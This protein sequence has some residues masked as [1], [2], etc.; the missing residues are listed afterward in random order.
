MQGKNNIIDDILNA[1]NK[2][3]AD[4]ISDAEAEEAEA[5]RAVREELEKAR[6]EHDAETKT[7][8]DALYA[9]RVKLGELEAGKIMLKAKRD[10][11]DKVYDGVRKRVLSMKDAEYLEFLG[12]LIVRACEDGDEVVVS[13]RD[14]KRANAAW[15]KKVATIAKKKLT[16]SK[17]CGEFEAGVILKGATNDRDLTIDELIAELKDRTE[18]DTARAL[19]L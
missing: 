14:A 18:A 17:T 7:A 2:A 15:L 10:C 5:E 11:V 13:E 12:A 16:L 8:A 9:G 6:A 1:A 4:I 3:A 19:G